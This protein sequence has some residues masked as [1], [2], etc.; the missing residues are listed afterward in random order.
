M[1]PP[2]PVHLANPRR[3]TCQL[4]LGFRAEGFRGFGFWAQGF[5][6]LG[7]RAEG[8]KGSEL[9]A[10]GFRGLGFRVQGLGLRVLGFRGSRV[11]K[12]FRLAYAMGVPWLYGSFPK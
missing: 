3:S 11:S 4:D 5:K 9:R 12:A 8:F 7:L 2:G 10:A 6:G 1:D